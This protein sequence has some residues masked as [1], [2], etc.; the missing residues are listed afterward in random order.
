MTSTFDEFLL[1]VNKYPVDIITLSDTWLKDNAALLDY[2]SVPGYVSVFRNRESIKGGGVGAYIQESIK[3]KRHKD[4]EAG[5][6]R[7]IVDEFNASI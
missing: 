4:I 3:F 2:V 6:K 7:R 1:T 5:V